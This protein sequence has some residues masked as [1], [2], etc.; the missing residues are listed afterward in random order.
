MSGTHGSNPNIQLLVNKT[1]G[2]TST[3]IVP[4]TLVISKIILCR[5]NLLSLV[6]S[7]SSKKYFLPEGL[8]FRISEWVI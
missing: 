3:L 4:R 8:V 5:R 1:K 2:L 6:F 7:V